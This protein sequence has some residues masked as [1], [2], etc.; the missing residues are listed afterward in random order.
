MTMNSQQEPPKENGTKRLKVMWVKGFFSFSFV[1]KAFS[2]LL[3][4]S[5]FVDTHFLTSSLLK[6]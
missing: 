4:F 6:I 3:S 5:P 2:R 1:S